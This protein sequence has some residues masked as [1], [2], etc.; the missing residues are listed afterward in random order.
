[1]AIFGRFFKLSEAFRLMIEPSATP[2]EHHAA[3]AVISSLGWRPARLSR[4][5]TGADH[6]VFGAGDDAGRLV[7]VRMGRPDR[8][9][10]LAEGRAL[11]TRLSALGVP[12]PAILGHGAVGP[13]PFTLLER[14][15]GTDLGHGIAAL[16]EAELVAIATRVAR[17]QQATAR[18]GVGSR[19]GYAV[20]PADGPHADWS[21]VVQANLDRSRQRMS[22]AGLFDPA[23][24]APVAARLETLRPRLAA[25]PAI[26]FLHDT[27]TRNVIVDQGRFSGIVD[28]DDLCWGDPRW[29]PALTLAALR[30]FGGPPA[31]VSHWLAAA[32][33]P[34]DEL[35]D[36][37]VAV[38]V[39]DLMAEQGQVF[40]GNQTPISA[41]QRAR[42]ERVLAELTR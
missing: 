7:V 16:S 19:F 41:E 25:Q 38:F 6:F 37:Y 11:M 10:T 1:M 18:L 21:G 20:G 4:F 17:A 22:A 35:F 32:G 14:L 42:L 26:P 3:E 40:N 9:P 31:Y 12:L 27:T 5:T 33:H 24:I 30:C 2:T 39:L 8:A 13:F 23:L 15:A 34:A 36:F 29:A 28:V